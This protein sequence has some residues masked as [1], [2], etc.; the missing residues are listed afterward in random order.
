MADP[1]FFEILNTTRKMLEQ[2]ADASE[3][4]E[5]DPARIPKARC[6]AL[7]WESCD[8]LGIRA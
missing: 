5:T 3:V 7:P 4:D 2:D 6:Y 1:G 8:A